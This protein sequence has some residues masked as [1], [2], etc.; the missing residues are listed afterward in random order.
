MKPLESCFAAHLTQYI[1][2]RRKLGFRFQLQAA[3]LH[4]FDRFAH[5]RGHSGTLTVALV[6][7]F[8]TADPDGSAN[9]QGRR[10]QVV[11]NFADYLATF[12]PTTPALD[13]KAVLRP[14]TRPPAHIY[15]DAE[16]RLLLD[17]AKR[18]SRRHP[19]RA[20][21][22]HAMVGLAASTGLRVGEV[23]N[24]DRNDVDL[25][26]GVLSV[27]CTKFAK[28][29]LVPLHPSTLEV[30]RRYAVVRDTRFPGTES[31]AF[32]LNLRGVR[33]S[34]HTV[35][36]DFWQLA[37]RAGLREATG[38]GPRFHDLRHTFAVRRLVAWYREGL[39]VQAMLPALA[40]YLG[41]VHYSDTAYYLQA[42][43]ELLG[44]AAER[45][46]RSREVAQ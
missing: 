7:D 11:R 6:L 15:T 26:S 14:K 35:Q 18:V 42:T 10:Y 31:S 45:L 12:E 13:P 4:D 20:Q 19:V 22:V 40:T 36:L 2:L 28:D 41:H 30:L 1:E 25:Q 44:V 33:Y 32:F 27:R 9:K 24:L 5:Q 8:A 43:A 37:R 38:S 39:D 34:R 3:V 29:R 21:T 16:L 46:Q 23:V 17:E